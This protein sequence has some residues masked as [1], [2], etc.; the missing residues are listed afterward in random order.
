MIVDSNKSLEWFLY[1]WSRS[2]REGKVER[3]NYVLGR[4][5]Q[6]DGW[7]II[8]VEQVKDDNT[9]PIIHMCFGSVVE[10]KNH[11]ENK[12]IYVATEPST[13]IYADKPWL[14]NVLKKFVFDDVLTIYNTGYC[15]LRFFQPSYALFFELNNNSVPYNK[16]KLACMFSGN[17]YGIVAGELYSERRKIVR[18]FE[19]NLPDEFGLYGNW[20]GKYEKYRTYKGFG[21]CKMEESS[22]YKF[23][24]SLENE[25]RYDGYVTEKIFD[26]M[27]CGLIPIYSGPTEYPGWCIPRDCYIAYDDFK[28]IGECV[29]FLRGMTEREYQDYLRRINEFLQSNDFKRS[30]SAKKMYQPLKCSLDDMT[31]RRHLWWVY[32][33][34]KGINKIYTLSSNLTAWVDRK[35]IR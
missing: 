19:K 9:I 35:I 5:L 10:V 21:E 20:A 3:W 17:K 23:M 26:A 25:R 29:S 27:I 15:N 8:P 13:V 30:F 18:Y 33:V 24:F 16:K 12:H 14:L 34:V 11:P 6:E 31:V 22:H 28:D 32:V 2:F 4:K 7:E 1:R